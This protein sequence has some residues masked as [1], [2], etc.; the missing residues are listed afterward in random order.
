[1]NIQ[2]IDIMAMTSELLS[3]TNIIKLPLGTTYSFQDTLNV[4]LHAATS[5]TNSLESASIDLRMKNPDKNV[6]SGDSIHDYINSNSIDYIMSAFRNINTEI[7]ELAH[8]RG[9]VHDIAID[10]HDIPYYGEK[11]TC[12]V[13]GI[14]PKNGTCWGYSFCSL[15]IIG[16]T[17]LT[18]D[19]ID[20]NGL[21]KNYAVLIESLLQRIKSMGI[22][23]KTLYMDREFFNLSTI[24]TLHK[25]NT[26]YII[27]ATAN[28]KINGML[29]DHKK[30]FG[31][32]ST[33]LE[34]QFQKGGPKFNIVAILNPN[35]DPKAK[36]DKGNN[37][38]FLFATNLEVKS[39][40]EFIKIIPEEY[41]KRWNIETGYKIK[42]VFKIRTCSKSPVV[43][44]L[45]FLIQCLLYN[46]LNLLKSGLK[47]T[48]YELKSA[49]NNGILTYIRKGYKSLCLVP[50]A[51]FLSKLREYNESRIQTLR[52][53]LAQI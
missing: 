24:S 16:E 8:L 13:R 49:I 31:S 33:I 11:N 46:I 37:E 5:V 39:T 44:V 4:I 3:K 27:A 9:T 19:A 36:K 7:I 14:K 41:K 2:P 43:R 21:T 29:N 42:N 22:L 45:F 47:T 26:Q 17:K 38:Y 25:L 32:A 51:A 34:Y 35:Y 28:K 40:S 50:I 48:V 10:F 53:R 52:D 30:K 15:D 12:G 23:V 20:I 1:M 6:P 18:L